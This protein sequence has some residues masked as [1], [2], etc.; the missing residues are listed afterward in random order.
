MPPLTKLINQGIDNPVA[1]LAGGE[2]TVLLKGQDRGGRNQELALAFT[3]AAGKYHLP[4][5]WVLLSGGTDGRD[6][7]TDAAAGLIDPGTYQRIIEAKLNPFDSLV[8]ND[9]NTSLKA[10]D[11][12]LE[13][14][15]T[16]T[17]VADLQVLLIYP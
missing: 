12:L 16:G 4:D 11:D 3:I 8:D 15:A 13:T 5:C 2:T 14:G 7:P 17:N 6:G 10:A 1:V 9:S